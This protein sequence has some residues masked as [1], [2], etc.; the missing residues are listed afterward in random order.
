MPRC[1]G[2][3]ELETEGVNELKMFHRAAPRLGQGG[4]AAPLI[5]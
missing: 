4:V 2:V 3:N 5:K 1:E